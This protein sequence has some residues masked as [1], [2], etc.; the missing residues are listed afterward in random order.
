LTTRGRRGLIAASVLAVIIIGGWLAA[1]LPGDAGVDWLDA[2]QDDMVISVEVEGTLQSIDSSFIGPPQIPNTWDYKISF[3][4]PEGQEVAAGEPI[5][6]FDTTELE[7][8]LRER[9]TEN[10]EAAKKIEQLNTEL[11]SRRNIDEMQLAEARG[12]QRKADLKLDVPK[13]L[14][15]G[16][17]IELARLDLE[18]AEKEITHLEARLNFSGKAGEAS[19]AVLNSQLER[20]A[21]QLRQIEESI[22][23]MTITAPRPGTVIYVSDWQG[24]KKKVGDSCWR[25]EKVVELPDLTRMRAEGMVDEADGGQ[26]AE[27]Q[28]FSIRLDAHPELTFKGHLDAISQTVQRKSWRNTAK[29]VNLDMALDEIDTRRM[30]PGMRMRGT[31]ETEK[32]VD[33]LV[34]PLQAVFPTPTGPVVYRR[35]LM[36]FEAVSV[37]LGRRNDEVVQILSGLE[38]GDRIAAQNPEHQEKDHS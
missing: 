17:V 7:R 2:R 4:A 8:Q 10:R 36:G 21:Q 13:Q 37:T 31:I 35:T 22:T 16:Q 9:T 15:K 20:T 12:R 5:L 1:S 3:M 33:V 26:V 24:Q 34:I 23:S 11:V 6:G 18:L 29:I 38:A 28:P 30:R 25:G 32:L 19:L 27:G 14:E